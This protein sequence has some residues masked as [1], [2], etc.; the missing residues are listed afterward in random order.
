MIARYTHPEMGRIWSDQRRFETWLL[1]ETAAA[2][3]MA[4]AGIVPRDAAREIR[5]RALIDVARIDEISEPRN[6]MSSP[7]RPRWPRP[8]D[9]Q[10]VGCTSG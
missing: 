5:E 6:T 4:A 7:S 10:P 2:E 3:A 9:R 1:V 8:S